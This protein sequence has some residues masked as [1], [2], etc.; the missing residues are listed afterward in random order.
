MSNH[1]LRWV[2]RNWNP[3]FLEKIDNRLVEGSKVYAT[4]EP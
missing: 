1:Y 2:L 4:Q 3:K